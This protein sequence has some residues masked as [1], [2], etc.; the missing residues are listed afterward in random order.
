MS[1]MRDGILNVL[2]AFW[3]FL[4]LIR[5]RPVPTAIF[6]NDIV[7]HVVLFSGLKYIFK[8]L[9]LITQTAPKHISVKLAKTVWSDNPFFSKMYLK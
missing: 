5:A 4:P 6:L 1:H 7:P 9:W 3:H 8:V 2:W